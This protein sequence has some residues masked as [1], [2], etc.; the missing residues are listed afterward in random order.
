VYEHLIRGEQVLALDPLFIG[1]AAPGPDVSAWVVLVDSTGDR[2][3]GLEAAQLVATANWLRSTT[4]QS[5]IQVET[6]G[7]RS[8]VIAL[9]AAAIDPGLFSDVVSGDGMKSLAYLIDKPVPYRSA[10]ELFCLDLYKEFDLDSLS[11]LASPARV[12][13]PNF[14]TH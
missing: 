13:Q 14:D 1:T 9:V 12:T 2:S 6:A 11:T 5:Q 3:L 8:Q 10:P 4:G 7:I